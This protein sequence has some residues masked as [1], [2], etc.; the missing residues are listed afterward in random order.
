MLTRHLRVQAG[1]KGFRDHPLDPQRAHGQICSQAEKWTLRVTANVFM[2]YSYD[3]L[4]RNNGRKSLTK[5]CSPLLPSDGKSLRSGMGY[6][7]RREWAPRS[8][9]PAK[10]HTHIERCQR[11]NSLSQ[12]P[13]L[14]SAVLEVVFSYPHFLPSLKPFTNTLLKKKRKNTK[15]IYLLVHLCCIWKYWINTFM[16]E[17][18]PHVP[19]IHKGRCSG[20]SAPGRWRMCRRSCRDWTDK[21][22][23]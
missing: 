10:T 9:D 23:T 13:S 7:C 2:Q 21:A 11:N 16:T 6:W 8:F 22:H 17:Q 15:H 4:W 5:S 18:K 1:N 19:W 20:S 14:A 3:S 12:L